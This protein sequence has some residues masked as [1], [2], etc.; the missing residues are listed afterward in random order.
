MQKKRGVFMEIRE[1]KATKNLTDR[2]KGDLRQLLRV[3]PYCRVSTDKDDQ[4]HS[5]R[6]QV[7]YYTDL[8][9]E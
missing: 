7:Q 8:V 6:S 3:A 5:Y 9:K 1:I 2:R 4:L